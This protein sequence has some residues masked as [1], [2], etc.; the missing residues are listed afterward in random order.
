MASLLQAIGETSADALSTVLDEHLVVTSVNAPTLGRLPR[1]TSADQRTRAALAGTSRAQT[2]PAEARRR[3]QTEARLV[4]LLH[5]DRERNADGERKRVR[6]GRATGV[7]PTQAALEVGAHARAALRSCVV[8]QRGLNV[9][10]QHEGAIAT[11]AGSVSSSRRD[12]G[13]HARLAIVRSAK[14]VRAIRA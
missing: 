8:P 14:R 2:P 12:S 9:R 6:V 5:R 11:A 3:E 10:T 1:R 7:A 13:I 4:R